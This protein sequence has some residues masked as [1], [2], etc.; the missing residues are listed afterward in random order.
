VFAFIV[1]A[2]LGEFITWFRIENT[3]A[4]LL[5]IGLTALL[6]EQ[7]YPRR[8]WNAL[9]LGF[10]AIV[11]LILGPF[12]LMRFDG[13]VT[14]AVLAA[15]LLMLRRHPN[16]AMAALAV[17]TLVKAWPLGLVPLFV[18]AGVRVR[19]LAVY[20]ALVLAG[21]LPFAALSAGG[22]YNGLMS[23]VD[24]HLEFESLSA[25]ILFVVHAHV[26]T[27]FET[28][29]RSLSGSIANQLASVQSLLQ[30]VVFLLAAWFY[31]RSRRRPRDLTQALALGVACA[32]VLGKVL[33]PQYLLWLTPFA[34][35]VDS[36]VALICFVGAC[37]AERVL[38]LHS[39]GGL[40]HERTR[41][42]VALAMRN[43]FLL[44]TTV[45]F[46]YRAASLE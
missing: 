14:A 11:P 39:F 37:F 46:G 40:D 19:G 22:S 4:W 34:A 12:S 7:L 8:R 6:L 16:W 41:A 17:G 26:H 29:S 38:L 15:L 32:A 27:Y 20:A 9:L 21:L 18:V 13:W 35:I 36:P 10:V 23:Q 33:S 2:A 1:P 43:A 3:I 24:R 42:V 25:S 30:I 45:V 28:G 31:A 44:A 5:V